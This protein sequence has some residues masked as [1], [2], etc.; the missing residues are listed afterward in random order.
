MTISLPE[1]RWV[2]WGLQ[3]FCVQSSQAGVPPVSEPRTPG[4]RPI[5]CTPAEEGACY[6][7][8]RL[9]RHHGDTPRSQRNRGIRFGDSG[10]GPAKLVWVFVSLRSFIDAR[11]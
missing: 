1:G 6:W 2:P 10:R 9:N 3:G 11:P 7:L 4:E 8:T 5:R